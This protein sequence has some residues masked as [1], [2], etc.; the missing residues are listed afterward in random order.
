MAHGKSIDP[1]ILRAALTGYQHE[2]AQIAQ[3]IADLTRQLGGK[4]GPAKA[5]GGRTTGMSDDGRRRI[6]A[7]Q[8]KRWAALKKAAG[9]QGKK[10]AA[11]KSGKRRMSAEGR[12]R[13]AEATRK[14][15][16][17]FRAKKAASKA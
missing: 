16:E 9:A 5:E 12:R 10:A 1:D 13:I 2:R 14:R 17:A 6:A 15:W 3:K 7:A 11:R 4:G 8:K